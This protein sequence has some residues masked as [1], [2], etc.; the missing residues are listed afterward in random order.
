MS[1]GPFAL[2][3]TGTGSTRLSREDCVA[4][5]TALELQDGP[6]DC[7]Y[8]LALVKLRAALGLAPLN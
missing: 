7:G 5:L 3:L 8:R 6:D 1:D 4:L 2:L